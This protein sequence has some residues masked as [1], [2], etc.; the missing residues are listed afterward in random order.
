[1]IPMR[2]RPQGG[3]RHKGAGQ[4][5]RPGKGDR[6]RELQRPGLGTDLVLSGALE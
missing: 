6:E 5:K 1:M 3:V 4:E 2:Y